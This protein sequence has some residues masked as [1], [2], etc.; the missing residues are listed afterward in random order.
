LHSHLISNLSIA[1]LQEKSAMATLSNVNFMLEA[2]S[3]H[4]GILERRIANTQA[5]L[6]M[7]HE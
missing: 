4:E 5:I 2:L 1:R 6:Q 3:H 7:L